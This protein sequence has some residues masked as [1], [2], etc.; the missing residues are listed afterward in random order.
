MDSNGAIGV[1]VGDPDAETGRTPVKPSIICPVSPQKG[2]QLKGTQAHEVPLTQEQ[3][4]SL[5]CG[6]WISCQ[7]P[8]M[9]GIPLAML[10]LAPTTQSTRLQWEC[11]ATYMLVDPSSGFAPGWV[12]MNGLGEVLLA[13]TDGKS[14]G[15]QVSLPA[16]AV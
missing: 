3:A 1:V 11:A 9:L 5:R 4:G 12:Q 14:G 6:S 13:R 2:V 15:S 7:V 16:A 10:R 8:T